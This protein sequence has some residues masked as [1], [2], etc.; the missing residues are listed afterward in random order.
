MLPYLLIVEAAERL[1]KRVRRT[2]LI[3]SHYFSDRLGLPIYFK[4]ENLQRTGSFKIRGALNFILAQPREAL[5]HGVITASAG[6]HGQGVAFSASL[7]GIP[8]TVFMPENTPLQKFHAVR[9]YGA[10]IVLTGRNFDQAFAS[11]LIRQ[12]ETGS[13][14]IHPFDDPLVIAGQGTIGLELLADIPDLTT[15]FVPIGGG[16][17]IAGVATALKESNSRI[18]IIGVETTAAPAMHFSLKKGSIMETPIVSSLADGIAVK[19]PG[20][21]TFRIVRELVDEVVLVEEEEIAQAIVLLLE[22]SKLLAE[23][24]GAAS[25]AAL[26]QEKTT[27]PNGKAICLLSGGNIDVKTIAMVVERGLVAGGRYLK[28]Q[29]ALQDI[30]GSLAKLAGEIATMKANIFHINHD[31]RCRAIPLGETAVIVELETRGFEHI[32]NILDHLERKGYEV[33]VLK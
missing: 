8:A 15:V 17:L 16:G 21:T 10:Q 20:E 2:E 6:N 12:Q 4:C 7:L 32:K 22:R 27:I 18:K 1:K 11:A 3:H 24:A 9:D 29:V 30:P 28:L 25:L 26:L 14:F 13:L 23:G 19:R 33:T 5:T 31:R